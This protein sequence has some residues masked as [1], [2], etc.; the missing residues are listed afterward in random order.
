V[1]YAITLL[2]TFCTS[3]CAFCQG[4][5]PAWGSTGFAI[6]QNYPQGGV[7]ATNGGGDFT[8]TGTA[9]YSGGGGGSPVSVDG[10]ASFQWTWNGA[11]QAPSYV[12]LTVQSQAVWGGTPGSGNC[13][14][15]LGDPVVP[16]PSPGPGVP[17]TGATSSGWR[18]YIYPVSNNTVSY[19]I[20]PSASAI[21][22]A[23]WSVTVHV[24]DIMIY[25]SGD[26]ALSNTGGSGSWTL[27]SLPGQY[28]KCTLSAGPFVVS[29]PTWN[30]SLSGGYGYPN[31]A[32]NAAWGSNNSTHFYNYALNDS[33]NPITFL[34]LTPGSL[35]LSCSAN[36]YDPGGTY[37]IGSAS[38][39]EGLRVWDMDYYEFQWVT[40]GTSTL[41]GPGANPTSI[42]SYN[43]SAFPAENGMQCKFWVTTPQVFIT[44]EGSGTF[45]QAQ[46]INAYNEQDMN[47]GF[48]TVDTTGRAYWL[49]N[50]YPLPNTTPLPA[51]PLTT[52]MPSFGDIPGWDIQESF[53]KYCDVV[54]VNEYFEMF[55]AYIPPDPIDTAGKVWTTSA[56]VWSGVAMNIGNG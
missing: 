11:T 29:S 13:A 2:I 5:G 54:S 48:P 26:L 14:D 17:P 43:P 4:S 56:F 15:G 27:N 23:S 49:D 51:V 41:I 30:N 42:K 44:Y 21:G 47:V 16:G 53:Y 34:P 20:N 45:L 37:E 3:T 50:S 24:T 8:G 19:S 35:T 10:P 36:I 6:S 33:T 39:A 46:L 7:L 55:I 32:L 28:L 25:V 52:A 40:F 31:I 22:E 18:Y 38:D 1:R 9:S 12:V